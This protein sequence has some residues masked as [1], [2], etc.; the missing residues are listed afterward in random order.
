VVSDDEW[1][2]MLRPLAGLRG[3]LRDH[4]ELDGLRWDHVRHEPLGDPTLAP[5]DAG[6][7]LF[8]DRSLVLLP[9]PG[10]TDGSMSL[11]VR[12]PG[13]APLLMVGDLTYDA[14]LLA[15]GQVPGAG[16]KRRMGES[17]TR[18][19]A[20]RQ[21]LPGLTVLAAHDPSAAGRLADSLA[22]TPERT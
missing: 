12:R 3:F 18:V 7:D 20:L 9:T 21:Q 6:H 17:I 8:G 15:A 4:I 22:V 1:A 19:N 10:H 14:D 13:H 2:S 16:D 11:L 5:F